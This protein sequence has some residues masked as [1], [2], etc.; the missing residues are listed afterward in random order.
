MPIIENTQNQL[1]DNKYVAE[2]F[3]D[4]KKSF[5]TVYHDMLFEKLDHYGVRRVTRDWFISYL[6][7]RRQFI[8][9]ENETSKTRQ[10]S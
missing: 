5:N 9:T 8:V 10:K 1:D 7:V 2:V 6:K 4:L 3:D